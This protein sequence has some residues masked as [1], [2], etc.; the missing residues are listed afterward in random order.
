MPSGAGRAEPPRLLSGI[1]ENG[2][3]RVG[4]VARGAAAQARGPV[5]PVHDVPPVLAEFDTSAPGSP[6]TYMQLNRGL[7]A[8]LG[9]SVDVVV[10]TA[11]R[12]PY[13]R[14]HVRAARELLLAA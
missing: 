9:R 2:P 10:T 12:N 13:V 14:A 11:M 4:G 1:A 3:G 7:E 6:D 5:D 8:I